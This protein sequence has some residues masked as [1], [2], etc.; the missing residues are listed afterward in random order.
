M[1]H[2]LLAAG[3][4]G[5]GAYGLG[6]LPVRWPLFVLVPALLA[7]LAMRSLLTVGSGDYIRPV[8]SHNTRAWVGFLGAGGVGVLGY[9]ISS[10]PSHLALWLGL[11][12]FTG[13]LAHLLVDCAMSGV[14]LLWPAIP[15]LSK[16]V[17][18]AHVKTEGVLDRLLGSA[19]LAGV[20]V[21]LSEPLACRIGGDG[22]RASPPH[23][24]A[25]CWWLPRD[26]SR[27]E[28]TC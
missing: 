2:T 18:L 11:A 15:S 28:S 7:W 9:K 13:W 21:L 6:W 16:R 5:F 19:A 10:N 22:D 20:I 4:A 12:V 3:V 25:L 24:S 23:V 1:T 17:T 26:G 14:P 8:L 27:H